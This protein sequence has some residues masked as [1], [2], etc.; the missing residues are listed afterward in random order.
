M[1][2]GVIDGESDRG[3]ASPGGFDAGKHAG[4]RKRRIVT[5]IW[6]NP[7]ADSSCTKPA[8]MTE[9]VARIGVGMMEIIQTF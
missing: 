8:L 5:D 7:A 9:G 2:C 1:A 4:G 3:G 6:A